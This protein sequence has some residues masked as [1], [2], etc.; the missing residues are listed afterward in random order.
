MNKRIWGVIIIILGLALIAGIVY[1][2][3]FYKF[4]SPPEQITESPAVQQA[5]PLAQP[6]I[7]E[8]VEQQTAVQP[9]SPL[10]KAEVKQEDLARIAA[11][12]AERFGSYSNQSDYGNIRDLQIF[13]TAK[14]KDWAE[15][16]IEDARA[17]KTNTVIYYGIITKSISSEVK[18]FDQDIGQAEVLVRTQRRESAGVSSNSS[19][20]YQDI[21]IKYLREKGVWRIDGVGWQS[22]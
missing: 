7:K 4:S 14:M 12:F 20:F 5:E 9:V 6:I 21:I 16:Y 17:R 10:K 13:M 1:V 8:P 11:A 15:N 3:F 22:K 19:T 2:I 18:Q